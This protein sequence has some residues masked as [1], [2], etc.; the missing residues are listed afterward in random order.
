[1][2]SK[3]VK[4]IEGFSPSHQTAYILLALTVFLWAI[5][6]VFARGLRADLPPL[7]FSWWRWAI[8]SAVLLPFALPNVIANWA[9]LR[10]YFWLMFALAGLQ[11]IGSALIFVGVN[12][13]TAING[14]VVNSSQPAMT[15][16]IALILLRHRQASVQLLGMTAAMIGVVIVM[17]RADMANLLGLQLAWGDLIIIVATISY[18]TYP[19]VLHRL[20]P[21]FSLIT[22]LFFVSGLGSLQLLPFY[23]AETIWVRPVVFSPVN[24][25]VL[26]VMAVVVSLVSIFFW[27]AGNRAVGPNRAAIFVNL[28][29]IYGAFLAIPFLG[30][31]L[32]LFH[33]IAGACV[34]GGI[35]MVIGGHRKD[36]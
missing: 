15:A 10:K 19:V 3:I 30:E 5:G 21:G 26:V 13:T 27:N 32:F 22:L 9:Y 17:T 7:G 14:T 8:A 6:I 11:M 25:L 24:I 29:P 23:I 36:E 34:I 35:L 18:A 4:S 20:P 16:I 1:M 2:R 28:L 31:E 33:I 12:Y